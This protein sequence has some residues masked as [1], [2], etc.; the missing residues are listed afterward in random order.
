MYQTKVGNKKTAASEDGRAVVTEEQ[1]PRSNGITPL[2]VSA[3]QVASATRIPNR[4]PRAAVTL[5]CCSS[6][7]LATFSIWVQLP[8][9]GFPAER[10]A[11]SDEACLF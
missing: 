11:L 4:V 3:L 6:A 7:L 10:F 8:G 1:C 5:L 9:R 2:S